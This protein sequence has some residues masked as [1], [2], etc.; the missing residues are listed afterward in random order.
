MRFGY[1]SACSL[2][3]ITLVV[4]PPQLLPTKA[5]KW[6]G[7]KDLGSLSSSATSSGNCC[8]L[9]PLDSAR[10]MITCREFSREVGAL[11][12]DFRNILVQFRAWWLKCFVLWGFFIFLAIFAGREISWFFQTTLLFLPLTLTFTQSVLKSTYVSNSVVLCDLLDWEIDTKKQ[13]TLQI[14]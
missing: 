7:H 4:Q 10:K 11:R 9:I 6:E 5:A 1:C 13:Y 14:F 12:R 8:P 3:R 2:Q